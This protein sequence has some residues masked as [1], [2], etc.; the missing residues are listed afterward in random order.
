MTDFPD[1]DGSHQSWYN[2]RESFEGLAEA[3]GLEE[4]L[5]NKLDDQNHLET[6]NIDKNY[7]NKVRRLF[8][9]L[10]K[11]TA[12]DQH[13]ARSR[14]IKINKMVYMLMHT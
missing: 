7:D 12:K 5:Y 6:R 4:I 14:N 11:A 3:A 10:K 9:I 13:V 2:F 1:F 8:K